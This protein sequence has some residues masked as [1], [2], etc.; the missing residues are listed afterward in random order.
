LYELYNWYISGA[1]LYELYNWYIGSRT[2]CQT[3][4]I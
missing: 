4:L 1:E 2:R 3:L